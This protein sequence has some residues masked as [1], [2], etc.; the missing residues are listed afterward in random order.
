MV[1]QLRRYKHFIITRSLPQRSS[2]YRHFPVG[3]HDARNAKISK[4]SV[5]F[6]VDHYIVR[7][8]VSMEDLLAVQVQHRVGYR[9]QEAKGIMEQQ[10]TCMAKIQAVRAPHRDKV[11]QVK[12]ETGQVEELPCSHRAFSLVHTILTL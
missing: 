2:L 12:G 9:R 7:F 4:L 8:K 1:F 6:A 5:V 10:S 3:R 11:I